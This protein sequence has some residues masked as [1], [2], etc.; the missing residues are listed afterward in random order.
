MKATLFLFFVFLM[1]SCSLLKTFQSPPLQVI[2]YNIKEL[3]STKIQ[4]SSKQLQNVK[5][6]LEKEAFNI[7]SV[8][9]IQFDKPQIPSPK[10]MTFGL[11]LH[12]LMNKLNDKENWNISFSEANTGKKARK[13]KGRYFTPNMARARKYADHLNYGLFPGQYSTGLATS[14][15]IVGKVVVNDLKWREFIPQRNLAK[16]L[17]AKGRKI[18]STIELFD[19]SFTDTIVNIK[20]RKVHLITLH[21]VPAFHFGNQKTPNYQR[22]A[23]QLR[24]LEW[25]LT[26]K[27]DIKVKLPDRYAHL[28]PLDEESIFIAMG[29]WNT[30]VDHPK[31]PGSKVLRRLDETGRLFPSLADVKKDR[32]NFITNESEGHNPKRM[33]LVLDY[34]YYSKNLEPSELTVLRPKEERLFLGCGKNTLP[35]KIE[36][37][38]VHV[39]YFDKGKNCHMTVSKKFHTAKNASD[40]FPIKAKF[41]FL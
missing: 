29:D 28:I 36:P 27:T 3:D 25:Y 39:T 13:W 8:N 35:P 24:F 31:N 34:L 33:K 9:E 32:E 23:D 14:Y 37:D 11:N 21:T 2:H 18:P 12:E 6:L 7:F 26:G 5:S 40:H 15:E 1:S 16:Y 41:N 22:N 30:E 19:K 17:D 20:G 10:Y 38:R 4:E